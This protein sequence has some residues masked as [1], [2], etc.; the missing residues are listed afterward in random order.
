MIIDVANP[1][2]DSVFK[3]LMED[4]RIAKTLLSALLKKD[5]IHVKV[6]PHEYSN[7][8][9]DKIS[10]FRIDFA[11]TI[12]EEDGSSRIVLIELQKTWLATETLRFRQYLGAQ[13]GNP[14]N[15][16]EN[17]RK[18]A[19]PMVAIYLLG[20]RL[21]NI[22]EP[23]VYVNYKA[24]NY[25]GEE[26]Q[27]GSDDPFIK[28]LNH[29]SIIVQ[30]P[31][32]RSKI[33]NRLDK[34]L[35]L[36][37]QRRMNPENPHMLEIEES[38]YVGDSEMLYMLHRLM[39]AAASSKVRQDM[40]AEDVY[41]SEIENRDTALMLKDK[42]LKEQSEQ[43]KAKEELLKEQSDQ[44]KEQSDQLKEQSAELKDK[45]ELLHRMVKGLMNQ[46]ISLENIAQMT[47]RGLDEIKQLVEKK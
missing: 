9:K 17:D 32:L 25:E 42:K 37:D 46:G 41:Y 3:Y 30:I 40:N 20:H 33:T 6:R 23:V 16:D 26:L 5:V 39:M 45:E 4:E 8:V 13:Y 36:F 47:G 14:H 34:I 1:I 38:S 28:S 21:G 44:L 12:L 15:M 19:Y 11:A 2:Y 18:Y 22:Q 24:Y 29:D 27:N 10:M 7:Q 31:L 35:S 43:L